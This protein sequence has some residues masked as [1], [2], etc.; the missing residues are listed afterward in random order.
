MAKRSTRIEVTK[1]LKTGETLVTLNKTK[2]STQMCKQVI[3]RL[4][5]DWKSIDQENTEI[6]E[7]EFRCVE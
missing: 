1:T 3:N 4:I 2:M 5:E 7:I 6:R